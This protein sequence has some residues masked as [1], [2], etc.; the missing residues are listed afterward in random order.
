MGDHGVRYVPGDA[1][2]IVG[3]GT[4]LLL[5]VDSVD[6]LIDQLAA[7]IRSGASVDAI[8]DALIAGGPSSMAAFGLFMVTDAGAR[9]VVRGNIL[10]TAGDAVDR[11]EEPTMWHDTW[12]PREQAVSLALPSAPDGPRLPLSD[13]VV[14]ASAIYRG[15]DADQA[16]RTHRSARAQ[17]VAHTSDGVPQPDPTVAAQPQSAPPVFDPS[18]TMIAPLTISSHD[19]RQAAASSEP[20]AAAP[21]VIAEVPW[22]KG[23]PKPPAPRRVKA[24]TGPAPAPSPQMV[25]PPPGAMPMQAPPPQG[26]PLTA[27]PM[28]PPVPP[29]PAA[30][31]PP[32][33]DET[34]RRST[35]AGLSPVVTVAATRCPSGHPNPT[36]ASSCRVC[37]A[38]IAQQEP[39]EI[40]RPILGQ[41]RL[42]T[43]GVILLDRPAIL[44]RNPNVPTGYQGEQPNLVQIPDPNKDVSGQHLEVALDYWNVLVRDLGSTNGTEVILP[45][46]MPVALRANDPVMIEPGS[47]VVLAGTVSFTYEALP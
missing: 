16:L 2:A 33:I 14:L 41:L 13:G 12:R 26:V 22:V 31:G 45:G 47:R 42:S 15:L 23:S 27:G 30:P 46:E 39:I 5:E 32:R 20:P 3:Q 21:P 9:M 36:Y 18:E 8:L 29:V 28:P 19:L 11:N 17:S 25:P 40:S 35:L 44:G 38:A 34:V 1:V 43:G 4:A 24:D 6:P 7:L 37:G 10:G